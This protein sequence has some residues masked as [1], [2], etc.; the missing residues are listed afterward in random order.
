MPASVPDEQGLLAAV[1][2]GSNSFHLA[3]ARLDHGQLRLVTTLSEKV[4]LAAGLDDKGRLTDE[5]QERAL[6]CLARFAQHLQGVEPRHL[7][8]VGTNALRVAR[9]ARAFAARAGKVLNHPVEIIAG[10]E[11]ARLIYVGVSRTLAGPDRRLVADIGGGSTEFII[12][13]GHQALATESLHMGCVSYAL[14]FFADGALSARA[15]E[16]AVTAARQEILGIKAHYQALGWSQ[17]VGSS[18]TIKA[19]QQV[20]QQ[21]GIAAPDGRITRRGLEDIRRQLLR[22]SHVREI[23][24]PGLKDDR[25]A[26]L[27]AGL[28]ILLGIFEEFGLDTMEYSDGAL[29]EGVLQDM[30]G[31]FRHEDIRHHS[32]QAI[33]ARYRADA[34]QAGRVAASAGALFQQVAGPLVLNEEEGELLRWAALVHE[35]G[36]AVAHNG[37]H[38]HSAYLLR[39]SDLPGF[40]RQVQEHLA[41]LVGAHRRKVKAEQYNEIMEAGGLTLLRLCALLRL[42]VLLHHSRSREPAPEVR[43]G[44]GDDMTFDLRFPAGWLASHPLSQEDF[45]GETEVFAGIGFKLAIGEY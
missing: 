9:N 26:L 28:A 36:T 40:S 25:K 2:L 33:Q 16:R 45:A 13:E 8:V 11:E 27:P 5:V 6:A 24:L 1:D 17:A 38:K 15:L 14:R 10:R 44:V 32:M 22:L 39:H 35:I 31:R 4:Q 43:L 41:L 23:D 20:Q 21:M 42:A 34:A 19:V 12:G 30:L 3:V 18:G 29:R 7:R 37:Y